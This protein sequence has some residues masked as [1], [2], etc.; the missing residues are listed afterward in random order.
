[1]E[2]FRIEK[3]ISGGLSLSLPSHNG[4]LPNKTVIMPHSQTFAIVSKTHALGIYLDPA[5]T[6]M[7]EQGYFKVLPEKEFLKAVEEELGIQTKFSLPLTN[8]EIEGAIRSQNRKQL[9]AWLDKY[10]Q[11]FAIKFAD[12]FNAELEEN[13]PS[14]FRTYVAETFGIAKNDD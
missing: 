2:Q 9:N 1:M 5:H 6:E 10:G 14:S 8:K 13:S 4:M 7:Y 12:I 11:K 3:N